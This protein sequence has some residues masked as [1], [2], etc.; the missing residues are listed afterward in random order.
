MGPSSPE[1]SNFTFSAIP[2]TSVGVS[3]SGM[4]ILAPL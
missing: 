2:F 1:E 3:S 4:D